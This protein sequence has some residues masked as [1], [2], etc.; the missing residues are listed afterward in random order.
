MLTYIVRRLLIIV[1]MAIGIS[2]FIYLAL[3][4]SPGDAVTRMLNPVQ[5]VD[6]ARIEELRRAPRPVR[7][8][9]SS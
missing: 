1:P 9:G 8:G 2:F 6:P 5:T 3:D 7:S 4:L